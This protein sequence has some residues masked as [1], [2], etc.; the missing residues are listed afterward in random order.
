MPLRAL[1][2]PVDWHEMLIYIITAK[3]DKETRIEWERSVVEGTMPTVADLLEFLNKYARDVM[4]LSL[5][6]PKTY[7]N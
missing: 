7:D 2:Q 5:V 3:L 1:K 4:P 6:S